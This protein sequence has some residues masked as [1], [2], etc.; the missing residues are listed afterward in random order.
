MKKDSIIVRIY[1]FYLEGFREMTLG[2]TLWL[3][4]LVKL[5]I[6]FF[7]LRLFFFPNYLSQFDN[8]SEKEKHVSD[9][10]INRA[11]TP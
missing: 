10:L 11:I 6:L 7:I 1:H 5:F 3:I 9:E 8:N 2:K 4:I